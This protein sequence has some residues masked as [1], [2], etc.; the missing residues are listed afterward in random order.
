MQ[1]ENGE[2]QG[3]RQ[4]CVN[5][6]KSRGFDK[7]KR[8]QW[9]KMGTMTGMDKG[10]GEGKQGR[11]DIDMEQ[12]TKNRKVFTAQQA[13]KSLH[14]Q[15]SHRFVGGYEAMVA[16]YILWLSTKPGCGMYIQ[17]TLHMK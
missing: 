1:G 6:S 14:S 15:R 13:R 2:K 8:R 9:W 12:D 3:R 5:A 16:F 7:A 11:R 17:G 4:D 10:K